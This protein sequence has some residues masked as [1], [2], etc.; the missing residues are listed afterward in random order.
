MCSKCALDECVWCGSVQMQVFANAHGTITKPD[1]ENE[2]DIRGSI[3]VLA[4][5]D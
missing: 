5:L 3:L 1:M 4:I 2:G